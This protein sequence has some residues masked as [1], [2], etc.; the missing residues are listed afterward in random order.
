M[1]KNTV[2][3]TEFSHKEVIDNLVEE[4][5]KLKA[6]IRERGIIFTIDCH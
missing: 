2:I 4:F 3:T 5:Y 6:E 1:P